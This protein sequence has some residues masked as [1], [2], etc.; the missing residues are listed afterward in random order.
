MMHRP[1]SQGHMRT[2]SDN[3][4]VYERGMSGKK[5]AIF[6]SVMFPSQQLSQTV[7]NFTTPDRVFKSTSKI[8]GQVHNENHPLKIAFGGSP[9]KKI[10]GP[11]GF[12][13]R[14]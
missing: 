7:N 9:M 8:E 5:P 10:E 13:I 1:T 11:H 3:I 12:P 2:S 4:Q 6:Q 14:I